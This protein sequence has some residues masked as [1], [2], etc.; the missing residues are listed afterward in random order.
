L[1]TVSTSPVDRSIR[2]IA[3]PHGPA[4]SLWYSVGTA[5]LGGIVGHAEPPGSATATERR[6][7]IIRDLEDRSG[8]AV[9]SRAT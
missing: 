5:V 1:T 4:A 2:T 3:P 8:V 6:D 7:L 9:A